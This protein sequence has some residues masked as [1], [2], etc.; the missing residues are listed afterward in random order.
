[1]AFESAAEYTVLYQQTQR[2]AYVERVRLAGSATIVEEGRIDDLHSLLI[3]TTGSQNGIL[4]IEKRAV[5]DAQCRSPGTLITDARAIAAQRVIDR[6]TLECQ[7]SNRQ[8]RRG[9]DNPFVE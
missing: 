7:T 4:I 1:M 9:D 3:I 8:A 2:I 5:F 6:R